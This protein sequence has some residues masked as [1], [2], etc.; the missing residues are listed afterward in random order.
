MMTRVKPPRAAFV[1]FPL[2]HQCGRPNDKALQRGILLAA[3]E[4]LHTAAEPGEIVTLPFDWGE[5][6]GWPDF[7]TNMQEMLAA[8]GTLKEWKPQ[9]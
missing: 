9:K 7:M 4:I 1:N 3:L 5:P 8:E 2:G 6:F